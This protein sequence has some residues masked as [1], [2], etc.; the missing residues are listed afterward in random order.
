MRLQTLTRRLRKKH[1]HL[2]VIPQKS[3]NFIW[4]VKKN[5]F[6]ILIKGGKAFVFIGGYIG[7]SWS[8]CPVFYGWWGGAKITPAKIKGYAKSP[9]T[10]TD[11]ESN[12][13]QPVVSRAASWLM[14]W[15]VGW[16]VGWLVSWW[17]CW[18]V[19]CLFGGLL[20][21]L[22]DVLV[23]WWVSWLIGGLIGWLMGGW[24]GWLVYWWAGWSAYCVPGDWI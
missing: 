24:F 16:L 10:Y 2:A 19:G 18:C 13:R 21:L 22:V 14:C 1:W 9:L 17:V 8:H 6:L 7:W 5:I 4:F 15:W 12:L 23:G 20:G 11:K 3:V